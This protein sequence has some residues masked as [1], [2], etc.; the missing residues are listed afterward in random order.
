V[1]I[2]RI[3][4]NFEVSIRWI[5][6]PLH[7]ETPPEGRTLDDLFAGRPVNVPDMLERLRE[8]AAEL[9]LPFGDRRYTFNSRLAQELGKWAEAEGR[10][11]AFHKAAF[12]AYFADGRNL[13]RPEVLRAVAER[14]GLSPETADR[15]R[16]ERTFRDSVDADWERSFQNG[17]TSVPT[18]QYGR[19]RVT[20]FRPP[21]AMLEWAA[22]AHMPEKSPIIG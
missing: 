10:G 13:A 3:R 5:A 17:V 22:R 19:E 15:V 20:G 4:E 6:F 12:H 14:A 11:D 21:E 18:F 1:G 9:K 8:V 16:A 2:E 7:P